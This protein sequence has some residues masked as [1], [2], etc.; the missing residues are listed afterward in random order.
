MPHITKPNQAGELQL[1]GIR[2]GHVSE[3]GG[4]E[5]REDDRDEVPARVRDSTP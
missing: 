5:G 2:D 1:V 4:H 3:L